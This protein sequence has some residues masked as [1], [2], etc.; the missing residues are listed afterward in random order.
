MKV[1]LLLCV[2]HALDQSVRVDP[3]HHPLLVNN[4][5]ESNGKLAL[6]RFL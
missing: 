2:D 4:I 3:V 5:N 6:L 1:V